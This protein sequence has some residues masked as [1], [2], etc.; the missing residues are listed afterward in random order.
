M[1]VALAYSITLL[2]Q[3]STKQELTQIIPYFIS[4]S[5]DVLDQTSRSLSEMKSL[6]QDI[7][8][9][10]LNNCNLFCYI[11]ILIIYMN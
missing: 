11:F 10:C 8:S 4:D 1:V 7:L 2:L 5:S 3:Q 6:E 9:L